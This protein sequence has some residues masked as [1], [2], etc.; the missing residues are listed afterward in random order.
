MTMHLKLTVQTSKP[1]TT[2]YVTTSTHPTLSTPQAE[3]LNMP[4]L[5]MSL[6]ITIFTLSYLQ[7]ATLLSML[8]IFT[9]HHHPP[10]SFS[11]LAIMIPATITVTQ[12]AMVH[13]SSN[14]VRH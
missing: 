9:Q 13:P 7:S 14:V 1:S 10:T 12:P 6:L 2:L 4:P 11:Q 3:Q 8:G 5:L